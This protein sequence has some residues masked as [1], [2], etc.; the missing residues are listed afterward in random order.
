MNTG[1]AKAT[2]PMGKRFSVA[3]PKT[4]PLLKT[5]ITKLA[6]TIPVS[7]EFVK[8]PTGT[9]NTLTPNHTITC[10]LVNMKCSK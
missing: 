4:Q 3:A 1:N 6:T 9:R 8:Y 5:D 7:S 10:D 2:F